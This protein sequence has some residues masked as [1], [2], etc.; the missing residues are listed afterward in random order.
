MPFHCDNDP[1][2][3]DENDT[4]DRADSVDSVNNN[5]CKTSDKHS[6]AC[7][8]TL[9]HSTHCKKTHQQR[10]TGSCRSLCSIDQP[11]SAMLIPKVTVAK[12][13]EQ[14]KISATW[15]LPYAATS[16]MPRSASRLPPASLS[17][18]ERHR[19]KAM[20]TAGPPADS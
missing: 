16:V 1:V 8:K 18:A 14:P 17:Q 2:I 5:V 4:D 19:A 13:L 15:K 12:M 9:T 7:N 20:P 10:V 3:D 6:T 11:R